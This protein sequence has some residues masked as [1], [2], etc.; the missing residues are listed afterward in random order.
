MRMTPKSRPTNRGLSV[1]NVPAPAQGVWPPEHRQGKGGDHDPEA[2][3]QHVDAAEHVVERRVAG[4]AAEGRSVVVPLR[5]Q[6]I[7]D[8]GEPVRPGVFRGHPPGMEGHGYRRDD[9]HGN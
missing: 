5:G 2:S 6:G 1:R 7:E 3:D 4:Q 9:E 8:L